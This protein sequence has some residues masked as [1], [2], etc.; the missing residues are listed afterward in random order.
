MRSNLKPALLVSLTL[1][2]GLALLAVFSTV[3][4]VRR[5]PPPPPLQWVEVEVAPPD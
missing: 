4:E 5:P 2:A 3:S 1:H